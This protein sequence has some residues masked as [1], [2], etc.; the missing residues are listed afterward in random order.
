M[1]FLQRKIR[2]NGQTDCLAQPGGLGVKGTT[3]EEPAAWS[4]ATIGR[5]VGPTLGEGE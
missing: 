5:A 4:F 1:C 2:A 3:I